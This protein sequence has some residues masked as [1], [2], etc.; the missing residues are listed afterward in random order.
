MIV[1]WILEQEA[2]VVLWKYKPKIIG[3][4]GNVGKTS[5]KDAI[6]TAL[7]AEFFVRKS[8]K[9]FNSDIGVPLTIL[10]CSNAWSNPFLWL[11]NFWKG[12]RLILFRYPYP[13]WL[14]LEIGA[15]R[16]DDIRNLMKWIHPDVAVVTRIGEVPV[17]VEYFKNRDQLIYEKSHLARGLKAGGV[18]VV[19]G[20]DNDVLKFKELVKARSLVVSMGG[21]GDLVAS[22]EA[23]LYEDY[24]DAQGKA[25]KVPT[26]IMC[27]INYQGNSVPLIRRGVLGM[28]LIYP[29]L[30][31]IAVAVSQGVNI[32]SASQAFANEKAT[33]GRMRLLPG[34]KDSL[35]IDDTYNA[36]PVATDAALRTLKDLKH[37]PHH[38][39]KKIAIL[40]DMLELGKHSSE[41]HKK[42][43]QLARECCDIL[44]T[45][46]VRA[47]SIAEGALQ[48][49]MNEMK[50]VQC[51]T[52]QEAGKMAEGLI[53]PGDIVLV[54]GSQGVRMEK[55]VLEIFADPMNAKDFLV[56]QDE[57]WK[58]R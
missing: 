35:I 21:E 1:V 13:Q 52:S 26:G 14:V 58:G 7:A 12:L 48:S 42:I 8:E 23:V 47:R 36:A 40:G 41:E 53:A 27:K 31:A 45:A 39:G 2:R 15:D 18:L 19:N 25:W 6:Y 28:H 50:I 16:P 51:D 29:M 44:I 54:K 55:A 10:G 17:H 32:V 43:G 49:G 33:P 5:T 46:G 22:H 3:V 24:V 20:D 30:C 9:S 38:K 4:T 34:I 37:D 56:R 57:E 11:E